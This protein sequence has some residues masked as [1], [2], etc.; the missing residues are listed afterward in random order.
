MTQRKRNKTGNHYDGFKSDHEETRCLH[1]NGTETDDSD[2]SEAARFDHS[3]ADPSI[4]Y[5]EKRSHD[6]ATSGAFDQIPAEEHDVAQTLDS[7]NCQKAR[8]HRQQHQ[9]TCHHHHHRGNETPGNDHEETHFYSDENTF[10]FFEASREL[11]PWYHSAGDEQAALDF[12]LVYQDRK[13]VQYE[14]HGEY[15]SLH[16]N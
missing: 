8:Q 10:E 14:R 12:R 15:F 5:D 9:E 16:W 3:Q 1:N 11:Q 13:L 7:G 6:Y 2:L 4:D